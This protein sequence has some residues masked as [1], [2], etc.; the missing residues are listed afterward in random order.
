MDFRKLRD[1]K[2]MGFN[3]RQETGLQW[4]VAA[5]MSVAL[6]FPGLGIQASVL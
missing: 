4:P 6:G 1:A 3:D 5:E 2:K